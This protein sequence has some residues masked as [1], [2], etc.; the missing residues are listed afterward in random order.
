MMSGLSYT[1]ILSAK[2]E[3]KDGAIIW[4]I[5]HANTTKY[6]ATME[7]QTKTTVFI[8]IFMLCG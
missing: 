3:H 6:V 8:I 5:Y 4:A 1:Y 7:L 2:R